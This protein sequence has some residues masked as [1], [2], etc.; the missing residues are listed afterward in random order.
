MPDI[1]RENAVGIS[2]AAR[3]K[4]RN[5]LK[6]Q[7]LAAILA[8]VVLLLLVILLCVVLYF[9][10]IYS[11]EDINGDKYT[12]KKENGVY[13]LFYGNGEK[14]GITELDGESCY[15][16]SFGTIVSVDGESGETEI[17]VVVETSGT[18]V[19]TFGAIVS[20]FKEMTYDEDAVKDK[21]MIIESIEVKNSHGSY[22]FVR[23]GDDFEIKGSER[24]PFSATS[25][26]VFASMCGRARSSRRVSEPKLLPTGEIDYAEYGLA[27]ELRILTETDAEG[28]E[29]E[30]EY[31]YEP[32]VYTI[33]SMNG[34][35][36]EIMVGDVTVTGTGFYAKYNGGKVYNGKGYDESA[37]RDTVYVLGITEDVLYGGPDS[38][39]LLNGRIESFVTPKIVSTMG[40][41]DYF[42]VS[43]FVIRDNIDYYNI[44]LELSEKFGEDDIGS[45]EFLAEYERL[46]DKYSHQ[47]CNFSFYDMEA[48]AGGMY[49]YT[50]YISNLKYADGYYLNS[51]NVDL[52]LYGFYQTE[53]LEVVKLSPSADELDEYGLAEPPYMVSFLYKTKDADGKDAYAEN[54]VDISAKNSDGSYYAYSQMYDMIVRVSGESF[55]FLDWDESNWYNEKYIQMSISHVDSILIESPAFSTEFKV[56]DSASRYLEYVA[57]S[58][59]KLT[60]GDVEYTVKK[61]S[62]GKYVLMQGDDAVKPYYSGDFLIAP[63]R[64]YL[65]EREADNYIFAESSETDID[66]DGTNDCVMYY[67]YDV[68]R[69]DNDYF[70]VAQIMLADYDGNPISATKTVLGEIAYQSEYYMTKSGYL[71]FSSKA[72]SVGAGIEKTFGQ[73]EKGKWGTGRVFVTA[74]GNQIVVDKDTGAWMEVDGVKCGLYLADSENS[75]LAERA[76]EIPAKYDANGNITRYSDIY[77]PLTDKKLAYLEDQDIIAAYDSVKKEWKKITYSDATVGVWGKGDY[78]ALDGGVTVLLDPLT[79]DIGE[80]TMMSNPLFAADIYSDGKLL[81]YTITRDGYSA[82]DKI[83]TAFQNF[84]ELYKYLLTAS[85]EELA[86]LSEEEK[87]AFRKMD[88]FTSG[89]NEACILKITLKASDPKGNTSDVVY[90][91]Y[92]YSER[93]VYVTIEMLDGSGSSSEQAYGNFSALYSFARKVIEDAQKVVS[94]QPVYSSDKY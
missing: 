39:E 85:F 73:Y 67:F 12:V 44:K 2:A 42:Y 80:V 93:R 58:Y 43:N 63:V 60:V 90:R 54:F 84:Q 83:A 81:D 34:D 49:A 71:F 51:D 3:I 7:R 86:E 5:M 32:A 64:Y 28:N 53:F 74:Q 92:R 72:S 75:R 68:I 40:L 48:R 47:V 15:I 62:S 9:A 29:L 69:T 59:R 78:Y 14:C 16:T 77:Y 4:K 19:G 65:G 22:T 89:E 91:F 87:E 61:D 24:T 10:D 37:A 25:F 30:K 31:L 26:A 8:A 55:A 27:S 79:G 41:T 23:N 46:F 33:T 21:S 76:A 1:K 57:G 38:L 88:D 18:E 11:F 36:H 35:V 56:E 52:M 70:L 45:D 50:P 94:A 82:S 13:A 6:K 66:G 17:K 20:L